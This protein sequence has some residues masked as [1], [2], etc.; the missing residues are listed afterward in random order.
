MWQKTNNGLYQKFEFKDFDEAFNFMT[1]VAVLARQ[2]NHHPVWKNNWNKVE[3]WL[4]THSADGAITAKD[5][6]LASAISEQITDEKSDNVEKK[7]TTR[8]NIKEAK[9]YT[10]GG[11]RGNPG[12]SAGAYV[13]FDL[14]DT[15]V[16]KNGYYIGITTNNQAEYQAL[17]R[18][19]ERARDLNI[20]KLHVYM[21]SLLVINQMKGL[22]KVKNR[23]LWAV[24]EAASQLVIESFESVTFTHV[25]REFNKDADAEVNRVLDE[26]E[27]N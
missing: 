1:S 4:S 18:G 22:F 11:S 13:I 24:Y 19:L 26:E 16:E 6:A 25:P 21:D 8:V 17:R 12:P 9:L 7:S 2:H 3:I 27:S 20:R 23:E 15:I 14:D 10:D 5:E